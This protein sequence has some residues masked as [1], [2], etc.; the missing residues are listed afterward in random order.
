MRDHGFE[1]D[2]NAGGVPLM[3][4]APNSGLAKQEMKELL[5]EM[6]GY[7][8]FRVEH[9]VNTG[10]SKVDTVW[11]DN[12]I[13]PLWLDRK[14]HLEKSLAIPVAGF[15]IEEKSY[16]RKTIR[17]DIDSL[18][19]LSPQVGILVFS[20]KIR[21][22]SL[23]NEHMKRYNDS[24]KAMQKAED[25]WS[26]AMDTFAK[27]S[28]ASPKCRIVLWEDADLVS[29]ARRLGIPRSSSEHGL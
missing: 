16:A 5:T 22:Y 8:G 24:R 15:E 2:W 26:V 23:Y 1:E 14:K 17:G 3:F 7:Y 6:G 11:F 27:F 20:S 18:N 21:T 12:R 13:D 19:S 28:A 10:F 29:A 4:A 25:Y 9:E